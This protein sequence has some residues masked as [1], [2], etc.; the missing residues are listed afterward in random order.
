MNL[1]QEVLQKDLHG[2]DALRPVLEISN[3]WVSHNDQQILRDVNLKIPKGK[4]TAFLGPSGCGKTTLLKSINRLTDLH[5]G[6]KVEGSIRLNGKEILGTDN[7]LADLRQKMGLLSQRPYPLPMNIFDN[8]AFGLKIQG[9]K[10]KTEIAHR[11]EKHLKQAALWDEVKDRLKAPATKLSIGQQ[12][13]LCLARGLAVNPEVILADEPTSALDPISSR[14]IEE[15]FQELK[16]DYTIILVTHILRQAK[17]LADNIVF[18]YLG[19]VIEQGTPTA[20]FETP[21]SD[22]LKNYLS[23]SH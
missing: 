6:M 4:I 19:A 9:I 7:E 15:Q 22:I 20:I 12:Q 10:N 17:W 1:T 3:L 21:Q 11:V 8:I 23:D 16:N 5:S 2:A 13:R 18:M 14:K